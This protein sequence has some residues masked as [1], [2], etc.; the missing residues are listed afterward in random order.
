MLA[1]HSI[2]TQRIAILQKANS[3]AYNA[4]VT[5]KHGYP[6]QGNREQ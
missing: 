6:L 3:Q 4:C 1:R 5:I 2:A